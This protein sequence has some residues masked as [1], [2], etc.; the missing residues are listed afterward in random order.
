MALFKSSVVVVALMCAG[1]SGVEV[2]EVSKQILTKVKEVSKQTDSITPLGRVIDV[3]TKIR[4]E[5]MKEDVA[6]EEIYDNFACFCKDKTLRLEK[7][8]KHHAS[9]ID[10]S[11]SNIGDNT[12]QSNELQSNTVKRKGDHERMTAKLAETKEL[13][14]KEKTN[15]ENV[16]AQFSSDRRLI[17]SALS[18]MK[19]SK[20]RVSAAS[21]LQGVP[22]IYKYLEM[23]DAMGLITAP[24]HKAAA[25]SL[26]QG[27]THSN[28]TTALLQ[29]KSGVNATDPSREGYDFHEGSDDIIDLV[30]DIFQKMQTM[31]QSKREEHMKAE[32]TFIQMIRNLEYKL[33]RNSREILDNNHKVS[34]LK[35]RTAEQ[36]VVLIENQKD[37]DET[38]HV[39]KEVTTACTTR[40]DEYD[41]RSS[42]RQ[43]ELKALTAALH[44]L[45]N[46]RPAADRQR[47]GA[48]AWEGAL[49]QGAPNSKSKQLPKPNQ[50]QVTEAKG[51]AQSTEHKAATPKTVQSKSPSFLQVL[52]RTSE[53]SSDERKKRALDVIMTE[54]QRLKS[55][56][57]TSLASRFDKDPF[58]KVTK[59]LSDLRF[60]LEAEAEQETNKKVWCDEEL[61][62]TEHSRDH[63]YEEMKQNNMLIARLNARADELRRSIEYNIQK[64]LEIG[65]SIKMVFTDASQLNAHQLELFNEQ[66]EARDELE[67]AIKILKSYYSGAARALSKSS[68][69]QDLQQKPFQSD[70]ERFR[71][72]RMNIHKEN[73]RRAEAHADRKEAREEKER[74]RIGQLDG[75]VPAGERLGTMGD[76]LALLETVVSDF[77]REIGNLEGDMS[78]EYKELHKTNEILKAQKVHAEE[79]TEL[80]RQE[81]NTVKVNTKAKFD[82]LQTSVDMLDDALRELEQLRPACID[83]GMSYADRVKERELEMEALRKALCILGEK[84]KEYNCPVEK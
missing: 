49:L 36:R 18:S 51:K 24:K 23:A 69:L 79:L 60:R 37:L 82:D 65:R 41:A 54:G 52:E 78:E 25:A 29:G 21:L 17:Q 50:T 74:S 68:L 48:G 35:K 57:L 10:L 3:L 84:G 42:A 4:S 16:E 44:C 28:G 70:S 83:T 62:R 47:I 40:A 34:T 38:D 1:V 67:E 11:S 33:D 20:R 72:E 55:V 14:Q 66:K 8:V 39:L 63:F 81:L 32:R 61:K 15:Y 27:A 31:Q 9:K 22:G 76:A 77:N 12:A 19:A 80:D 58:E 46:A 73:T 56:M 45:A 5:V 2:D 64:A 30:E 6:E 13:K 26:L 53:L 75:D 43:A 7:M 71:A 59:L